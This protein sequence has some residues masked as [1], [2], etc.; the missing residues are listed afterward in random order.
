MRIHITRGDEWQR[1]HGKKFIKWFEEKYLTTV[2]GICIRL[3][4]NLYDA[5][6]NIGSCECLDSIKNPKKF[7]IKI[8]A[9]VDM[10]KREFILAIAHE[11]VHLKQYALN[12]MRDYDEKRITVFKRMPYHWDAEY[13]DQPWE[14]EA[15]GME[16][17]LLHRYSTTAGIY[18]EVVHLGG[19]D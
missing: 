17:G 7:L 5:D 16:R 8:G 14:I 12:E 1:E 6:A 11:M 4:I 9:T 3:Q 13:W 15:Y 19:Y 2:K 10:P 18:S